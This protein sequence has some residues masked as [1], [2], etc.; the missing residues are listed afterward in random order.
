ALIAASLSLRKNIK[1]LEQATQ[2]LYT[3]GQE[4]AIEFDLAKTELL[5]F[6]KGKGSDTPITLPNN[7]LGIWFDPYLTFKEHIRIRAL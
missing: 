4:N 6:T 5:H 1:L 2:T 3:L 7:E